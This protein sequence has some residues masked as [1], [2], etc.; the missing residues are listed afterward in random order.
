L[1]SVTWPT[2]FAV[3]A[4]DVGI[5]DRKTPQGEL[6]EVKTRSPSAR[7]LP[8]RLLAVVVG[9]TKTLRFKLS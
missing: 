3:A 8:T 7:Q 6:N 5:V 2:C 4:V 9:W 1:P